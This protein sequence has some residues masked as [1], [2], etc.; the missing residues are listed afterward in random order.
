MISHNSIGQMLCKSITVL[1]LLS[2]Q[3]HAGGIALGSTRVI[4]PA[5]SKQ[6]SLSVR[7][8][9][10]NKRYLIQSWIEGAPGKKTADFIVTPPVF[11]SNPSSE[12]ALRIVYAGKELPSDRESVYWINVKS[13]PAIDKS[14]LEGKNTLQLAVLSRI[15]MF[16]RPDGLTIPVSEA[17]QHINFYSVNGSVQMENTSPYYVSAI[18][19]NVNG[20]KVQNTM[21]PPY[22]HVELIS[23]VSSGNV[24]F[25]TVNDYGAQTP[26]ITKSLSSGPSLK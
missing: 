4:Y 8:S 16:V 10:S 7:N 24:N 20:K 22:S 26:A 5:S 23:G 9:D 17:P 13:I 6:V 14:K 2:S 21:V 12:N 18:N 15:K 3:V 19:I 11:A 1:L 25:Q